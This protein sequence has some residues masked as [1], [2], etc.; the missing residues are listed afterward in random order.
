MAVNLSEHDWF[1]YED[2]FGT[3]EEKAFVKY[4]HSL[5]PE[6]KKEYEEIYLIRNEQLA[7]L[8][9]YDFDMGKR[10]EPDFLL[11]L[12]RKGQEKYEQS[13]IYIEAKGDH[14]LHHKDEKWKEDF[15]RRISGESVPV[16][17]Y[18]DNYE[19]RI[20]GLP[21]F[22]KNYRLEEFEARFRKKLL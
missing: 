17:I 6:L 20:Y 12:R 16:N 7:E 15:L 5:I 1:V 8:A 22:N 4:F 14:L 2:H 3:T 9:I 21:F 18:E 13:Q 10:F 19:Y 11:F